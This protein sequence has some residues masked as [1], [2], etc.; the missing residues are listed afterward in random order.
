[1]ADKLAATGIQ[2]GAVDF[3]APPPVEIERRVIRRNVDQD[4]QKAFPPFVKNDGDAWTLP[5]QR[6]DLEKDFAF[7]GQGTAFNF[8]FGI[9]GA[10]RIGSSSVQ[11]CE[12]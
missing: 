5:D 9:G 7:P 4:R 6:T 12:S 2:K 11:F 1:M 8:F 10:H 3:F